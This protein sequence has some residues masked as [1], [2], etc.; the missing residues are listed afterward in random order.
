[1]AGDHDTE[2]CRFRL[3][4]ELRQTVQDVDGE[5]AY[6][7]NFSLGQFARP[8]VVIDVASDGGYR[9]DGGEL[10]ENFGRADVSGVNDVVR[11]LQSCEGFGAKQS[12][13]VGDD[14]D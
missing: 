1:M 9:G 5:A 13:S 10:S 4:V 6:F 8:G 12:V 3:Q 11:A 7:H 14:A 2:A